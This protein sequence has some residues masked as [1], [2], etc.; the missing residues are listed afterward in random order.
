M[1]IGLL[2]TFG[3]SL[4]SNYKGSTKCV[5][6]N[7][8]QCHTRPTLAG[9]NSNEAN[10]YIFTVNVNRCSGSCNSIDDPHFRAFFQN[11]VKDMNENIFNQISWVNETT[12]INKIFEIN[13][14]HIFFHGFLPMFFMANWAL[15]EKFFFLFFGSFCSYWK[16][17]HF[18]RKTEY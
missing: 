4:A 17:F 7:N 18:G 16:K 12:I 15:Q 9:I 8:W 14:W 3:E 10:F 2:S 1:F 6:L 5:S 13:S 11:R